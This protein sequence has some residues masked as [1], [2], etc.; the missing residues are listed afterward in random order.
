MPPGVQLVDRAPDDE[1][2]I[3]LVRAQ[4]AELTARYGVPEAEP[5][6]ISNPGAFRAPS[7]AFVGLS[8]DDVAVGCGGVCEYHDTEPN[9]SDAADDARTGELKAIYVSPL[10]RG[11]GY[12]R[13]IVQA[14]EAR[15]VRLGYRTLRL[16]TGD[17]QPEAIA[18]YRSLGYAQIERYGPY[19][20]LV[21]SVCF[22]R[23]L[24]P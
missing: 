4:W 6:S 8:V 2:A 14:L 12:G 21:R 20:D 23:T 19:R 13:L 1:M 7:G 18:L 9:A 5:A 16:E 22:E 24:E 11:H 17:A 3:F 15:A 10:H